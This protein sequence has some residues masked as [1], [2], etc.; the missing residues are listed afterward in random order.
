M[1]NKIKEISRCLM[2]VHKI[3]LDETRR[4]YERRQGMRLSPQDA[5]RAAMADPFFAWLRPVSK[6][7]AEI[8]ELLATVEEPGTGLA[9]GV[10]LEVESLLGGM[11]SGASFARRYRNMMQQSPELASRH[12]ELKIA[13]SDLPDSGGGEEVLTRDEWPLPDRSSESG[14]VH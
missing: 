3:L 4:D 10:R 8:D 2:A 12:G 1:K 9:H 6:L 13:L 14:T 5:W 11:T 7:I